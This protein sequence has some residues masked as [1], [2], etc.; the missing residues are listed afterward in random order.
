MQDHATSHVLS[1]REVASWQFPV[2]AHGMKNDRPT[3]VA[4]IPSLQRGAVWKPQQVEL[5][6]DSVL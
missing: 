1:L 6:W 5:L 2:L 3:I 4:A